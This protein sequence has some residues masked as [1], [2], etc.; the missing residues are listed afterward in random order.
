MNTV[1]GHIKE[2][3]SE[4]PYKADWTGGEDFVK[5]KAIINYWGS[6]RNVEKIYLKSE[7]EEAK[8]TGYVTE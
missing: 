7:W 3:R 6:P 4:Q 8:K 1:T 2:I 5:V